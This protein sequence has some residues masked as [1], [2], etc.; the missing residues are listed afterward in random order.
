MHSLEHLLLMLSNRIDHE[1]GNKELAA[2]ALTLAG[3]SHE[4]T[5]PDYSNWANPP[6]RDPLDVMNEDWSK[7]WHS[8]IYPPRRPT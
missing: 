4:W 7:R 5:P 8:T 1:T 3:A 6:E 2:A